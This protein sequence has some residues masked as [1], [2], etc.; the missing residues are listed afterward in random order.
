[1]KNIQ[2][3]T[4]PKNSTLFAL[5]C[6]G[7]PTN[8]E[9][10]VNGDLN[11]F[12]KVAK[13]LKIEIPASLDEDFENQSQ[14][15]KSFEERVNEALNTQNENQYQTY[16]QKVLKQI[17]DDSTVLVLGQSLLN[18]NPDTTE[19]EATATWLQQ[20]SDRENITFVPCGKNSFVGNIDFA[21][22]F[23]E[24]R[25][26]EFESYFV[27]SVRLTRLKMNLFVRNIDI[28]GVGIE[29][30][31]PSNENQSNWKQTILGLKESVQYLRQRIKDIIN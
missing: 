11:E 13:I 18:S 7:S 26:L 16:L 23:Q 25:K 17:K 14:S 15:W 19:S 21:K 29:R 5:Q 2:E 20:N 3:I 8:R 4:I 30:E 28:K 10:K 27:D 9:D 1:M 6:F 31:E 24:Q 12:K 22:E